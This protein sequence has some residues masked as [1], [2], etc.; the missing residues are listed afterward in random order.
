MDNTFILSSHLYGD[1]ANGRQ[2]HLLLARHQTSDQIPTAAHG[3]GS[4]GPK[5][6]P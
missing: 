2:L 6:E 5:S 4:Y 1:E 3:K